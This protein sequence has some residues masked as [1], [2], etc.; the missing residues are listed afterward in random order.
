MALLS[1]FRYVAHYLFY[2]APTSRQIALFRALIRAPAVPFENSCQLLV[3]SEPVF[4]HV[5][6]ALFER[7]ALIL[8]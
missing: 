5:C 8:R 2:D 3:R 7:F 6:R 1:H 4:S